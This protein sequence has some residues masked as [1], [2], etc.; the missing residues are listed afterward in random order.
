MAAPH[1]L[2]IGGTGMLRDLSLALAGQGRTV[3]VVARH[4]EGL[5]GLERGRGR[6]PA[7]AGAAT[8]S[9]WTTGIRQR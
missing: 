6:G 5:A 9:P 7:A 2:V 4:Q 1:A 8:P 3:S